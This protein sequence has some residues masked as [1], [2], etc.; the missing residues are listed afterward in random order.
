MLVLLSLIVL[1][2]YWISCLHLCPYLANMFFT[3][4][5]PV[6]LLRI[7]TVYQ[8]RA[9]FVDNFIFTGRKTRRKA[10]NLNIQ[11]WKIGYYLFIFDLFSEAVSISDCTP[12]NC[13]L[14]SENESTWVEAICATGR[15]D[16][17]GCETS[18]PP[19][20]LNSLLTDGGE[21]VRFT[22]RPSFTPRKVPGT[23]FC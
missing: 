21:V 8:S 5:S 20:F 3:L 12:S 17:Y 19:H 4:L 23:H 11:T 1:P 18:S 7:F 22:R 10:A 2:F 14:I 15:G 13:R 9:K 16:P 6:E